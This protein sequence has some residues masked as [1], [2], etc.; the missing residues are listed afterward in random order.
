MGKKFLLGCGA[1]ILLVA[2]ILAL[3]IMGGYNSL[4]RLDQ[5]TQSQW[6]QVE[7]AYQRRADLV[8]L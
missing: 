7:N 5:A 3:S 6:A 8:Q 2:V 1:A 4:V